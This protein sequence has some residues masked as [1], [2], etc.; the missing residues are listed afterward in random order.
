MTYLRTILGWV[1][2]VG[3][4]A[5]PVFA[6]DATQEYATESR[7]LEAD[8]ERYIEARQREAEA[9]SRVRDLARQVDDA[10]AD[11]NAPVTE[12]RTLESSFAAGRET[13]FDR[14]QE[15]AK[16]RLRMYDRMDRLALLAQQ[17]E[18][19]SPEPVAAEG[20]GPDGRWKFSLEA[21]GIYALVDLQFTVSGFDRSFVVS[22]PYRTSNGH[23]GTVAGTFSSN[24][25]TL[26]V[27]DSR[28]GKVAVL[29]G[30][31]S[32]Q[33]RLQGTWQAVT[34]GLGGD[35]PQG[36]AWSGHRVAS[37]SEATFD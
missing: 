12:L 18:E 29:D 8:L 30:V 11:P 35:R 36:G 1:L 9:I 32:A 6:Q 20:S 37:A 33:G 25:L 3:A 26:D 19:R 16:A 5:L 31:V 2:I 23:Q 7:L 17:L 10:L 4:I 13:A 34:T 28:R 24:R 14:L 21:L 15:T 22:G 27:V